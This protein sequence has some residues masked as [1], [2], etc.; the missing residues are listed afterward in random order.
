MDND[1]RHDCAT[2]GPDRAV[3]LSECAA[4]MQVD[5]STSCMG[6]HVPM[7]FSVTSTLCAFT[8]TLCAFTSTLCS[9]TST[10]FAYVNR[11]LTVR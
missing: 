11:L 5:L 8:S 1:A 10:L 4:S 9:F 6:G 7:F 2:L 3:A